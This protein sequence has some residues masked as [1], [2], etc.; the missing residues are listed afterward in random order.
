VKTPTP[1]SP[2]K[3]ASGADSRQISISPIHSP[4]GAIRHPIH[5]HQTAAP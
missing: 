2:S 1:N 5:A 4:G 3:S